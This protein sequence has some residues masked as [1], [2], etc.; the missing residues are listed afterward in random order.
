MIPVSDAVRS[1]TFPY[2][3]VALIA[4]CVLV[5]IYELTLSAV[6]LDDFFRD[7][8]VIPVQII[9]WLE[10]PSGVEEPLTVISSAFIH[11]GFLHLGGNMLFLWVFGDNVEDALGHVRYF[12]F[13]LVAAVGAVALQVAVDTEEIIP[14]IGASGA[15]AG[16]LSGYLVLYPRAT[17]R[18]LIPWLFFLGS[19]P[20][21]AIVLIGVWF[22]LQLFSGFAS[23]GTATGV[24][25]G[26]AVWAHVGGFITGLVIVLAMRPFIR[27]R[28]LPPAPRRRADMW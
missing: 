4:A 1:R 9:N 7:H 20:V 10:E 8:G 18:V 25:E 16:V 28:P 12:L 5:F 27:V 17:V 15:I 13:Y 14:M 2:V 19:F 6:Q 3:N 11:G 24:S 23:M 26:I 22:V 21:P